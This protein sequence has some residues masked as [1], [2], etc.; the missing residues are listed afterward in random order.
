M[1]KVAIAYLTKKDIILKQIVLKY[2]APYIPSRPEGFETLCKLILEQQ[3]SL[4]SA[5]AC[6]LKVKEDEISAFERIKDYKGRV[7][8]MASTD[9]V[10]YVKD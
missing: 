8:Q 1:S 6:F 2:G 5:K 7:W 10:K 9:R 4:A 3:V